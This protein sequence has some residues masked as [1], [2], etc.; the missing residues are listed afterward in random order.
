[1]VIIAARS[2]TD[3]MDVVKVWLEDWLPERQFGH[4]AL[5]ALL[6]DD[7]RRSAETPRPCVY[8]QKV[9]TRSNMDFFCQSGG[10]QPD[11]LQFVVEAVHRDGGSPFAM[12]SPETYSRTEDFYGWGIND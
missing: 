1:M 12:K 9:A 3:L 2:D 7:G 6:D 5:V 8:L 10:W 4:T 11:Q